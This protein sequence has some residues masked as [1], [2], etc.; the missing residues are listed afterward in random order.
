M[1]ISAPCRLVRDLIAVVSMIV[2]A[3]PA[4]GTLSAYAAE[5]EHRHV[6]LISVDGLAGFYLDDEKA[7]IPTLRRLARDGAVSARLHCSFPTVTWPNHTSLVTG[8]PPAVHGILGNNLLD[9]IS[10][11]EIKLIGDPVFDKQQVVHSPTIYDAAHAAGLSTA[12]VAWPATRNAPSLTWTIPDVGRQELV[13]RYSTPEWLDELRGAGIP[14]DLRQAWIRADEGM[15]RCDWLSSR[16]AAHVIENHQPALVLLHL[17]AVDSYQHKY[18][19]G[20]P[21]AY[22]ALS[23]ADDRVRDVVDAI[24]RA[25]IG[26]STTVLIVSDHG[27]FTIEK[28]IQPN[29]AMRDAGLIEV[30]GGEIIRRDAFALSQGGAAAVYVFDRSRATEIA[31]QLAEQ[32]GQLEG[33]ERV[34]TSDEFNAVGQPT[35]RENRWAPDLWLAAEDGYVFWH[36]LEGDE[37]IV[38]QLP[39]GA[40]SYIGMHGYL[41]DHPRM[42]GSLIASGAGIRQGV[43]L[44]MVSNLDVAPTIARLLGIEFPSAQGKAIEKAMR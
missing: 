12:G 29:I 21:E 15:V 13:D 26:D 16:A 18:G 31:T 28:V 22:W 19:P 1:P 37:V 34:I 24:E 10:G 38:D 7:H 25:G 32:L 36:G 43:R 40:P 30:S 9:R 39:P 11:E 4:L 41:P 8:V 5:A 27:F 20:T 35:A 17:L 3:T 42:H 14:I 2:L 33:V 6:V 44:D 23:Y